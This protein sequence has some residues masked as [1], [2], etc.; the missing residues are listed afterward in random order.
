[1]IEFIS[2]VV[3]TFALALI[4]LGAV[5]MWLERERGR[6]QGVALTVMGLLTGVAYAFLG[7]RFAE[8]VFGRL[9]VAVDLPALMATAFTYTTGVLSGTSLAMGTFLWATGRFRHQVARTVAAFVAVG[10]LVAVVATVIAV[11]LSPR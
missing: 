7:S 2:I 11:S 10:V 1:M 5:T 9:I 4:V 3:L 6:L 8:M